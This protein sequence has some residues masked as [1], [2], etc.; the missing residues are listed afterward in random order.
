MFIDTHCH[1]QLIPRDNRRT[2]LANAN[3]AQ[4]RQLVVPAYKYDDWLMLDILNSADGIAVAKGIHPWA[5]DESTPAI[6]EALP[7]ALDNCCAIGETGLDGHDE[8]PSM[9]LQ[10]EALERHIELA[11]QYDLPLILHAYKAHAELYAAL[12]AA[13]VS[14]GV[15]HAFSGSRQQAMNYID[16]GFKIGVG[17][18]I[19]YQRASKTRKAIASLPIDALLLETD[20]P[21]MPLS[22]YQGKP[23][24]PAHTAKIAEILAD[25]RNEPLGYIA[26]QTSLNA[27]ELFKL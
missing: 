12:K 17:G 22:G 13:G 18:V 16:L 11:K 24:Q 9:S 5:V 15:V 21:S 2:V 26:E 14:K 1:L 3:A 6:L 25:L 4:V 8:R 20:S 7:A 23:N 19:S 10:L 27:R